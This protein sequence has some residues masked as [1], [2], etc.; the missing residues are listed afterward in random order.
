[1]SLTLLLICGTQ[2]LDLEYPD[3][4]VLSEYHKANSDATERLFGPFSESSNENPAEESWLD[5]PD[6]IQDA[7]AILEGL[8]SKSIVRQLVGWMS[9][10]NGISSPMSCRGG[11]GHFQLVDDSV[12]WYSIESFNRTESYLVRWVLD[13]GSLR[14]VSRRTLVPGEVIQPTNYDTFYTVGFIKERLSLTGPIT[15]ILKFANR[16]QADKIKVVQVV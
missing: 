8:A 7:E 4:I 12:G 15:A 16:C 9:T 13:G 2:Q 10:N 3:E 1:M 5:K 14:K 6:I 11:T